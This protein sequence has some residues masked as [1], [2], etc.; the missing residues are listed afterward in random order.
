MNNNGRILVFFFSFGKDFFLGH[1]VTQ[2]YFG[3]FIF[4]IR[5]ISMDPILDS[6]KNVEIENE[7][8]FKYVLIKVYGKEEKSQKN[9]VR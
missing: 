4:I 9:I 6:I 1:P 7:G 3:I 2:N 5:K 8:V